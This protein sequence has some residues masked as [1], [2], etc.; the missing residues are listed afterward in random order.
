MII[1]TGGMVLKLYYVLEKEDYIN[2]NIH[3]IENNKVLKVSMGIQRFGI[4]IL[5]IIF[6]VLISLILKIS[7]KLSVGVLGVVSIL[8]V[9]FYMPVF[10]YYMIKNINKMVEK[11]PELFNLGE[12]IIEVN[13]LSIKQIT[14]EKEEIYDLNKIIGIEDSEEYTYLYI[15]EANA[16]IIP[17]RCFNNNDE[18]AN[19]LNIINKNILLEI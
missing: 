11:S 2:F 10:K 3:H 4:P 16:Y 13:S 15:N 6:S 5:F 18:K 8:W 14:K 7:L 19:F 12:R 17:H 9:I 1:D